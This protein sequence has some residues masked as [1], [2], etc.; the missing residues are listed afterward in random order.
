M[1]PE[2]GGVGMDSKI[3]RDFAHSEAELHAWPLKL[4]HFELSKI[5]SPPFLVLLSL[6]LQTIWP[7]NVLVIFANSCNIPFV[8]GRDANNVWRI[9]SLL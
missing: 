1:D 5:H 7:Q 2:F 9:R 8:E 6:T 4:A 3:V